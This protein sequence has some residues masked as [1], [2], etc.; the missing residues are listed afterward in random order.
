[1]FTYA[2]ISRFSDE[3]LR[4]LAL[5]IVKEQERRRIEKAQERENWV[6]VK[7]R[8]YMAH[9][10]ADAIFVGNRTIVS[11]Y[12]RDIGVLI[13]TSYPIHGDVFDRDVGIAVAYAKAMGETIPDFI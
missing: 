1:M 13:G 3:E 4:T 8:A 6:K 2:N 11:L 12:S 10:N 9:P 5:N 7:V